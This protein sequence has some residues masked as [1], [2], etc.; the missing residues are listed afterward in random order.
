MMT[1]KFWRCILNFRNEL[2]TGHVRQIE[3]WD[4]SVSPLW[5]QILSTGRPWSHFLVDL[6]QKGDKTNW[7]GSALAE[8]WNKNNA[9]GGSTF[10]IANSLKQS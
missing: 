10:C 7:L 5:K 9:L 1:V 6:K 8:F 4:R 2:E 3:K